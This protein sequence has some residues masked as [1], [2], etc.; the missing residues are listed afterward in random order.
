MSKRAGL[1]YIWLPALIALLS[2]GTSH[3][4]GLHFSQYY[5]TPM[6]LNPANTAL[7]SDADYRLGINY[8][9]QWAS[10][11]VPFN[12]FSAFADFQLLR[13]RNIT[14]WMGMG[15]A[16]FS[17]K[18]GDGQLAM[19]K[20]EGFLAYHVQTGN[21]S[22]FSVGGSAAYVQRSVDYGKL[23]FDRQWDGFK[24]D[25]SRNSMETGYKE[26]TDF[27]D[28]SAGVNYAYYPSDRT[29]IK[30]GI[31]V[32][33]VN[34]PK[35][36]FYGQN[37]TLKIRPTAN[38]D[39]IFIIGETFTVNPSLY[40]TR[41]AA[42]QQLVY[43]SQIKAFLS[44]DNM[45]NPTNIIAGIYHRYGDAIIG[46]LGFQWAGVKFITSYD[47]TM[48]KLAPTIRSSGALEFALIYEGS[49]HGERDKMNCPRF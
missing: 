4:Q 3:A 25:P 8:R 2:V 14:N 11:P 46:V 44:E 6:L 13:N 35:E 48:S 27:V 23:T 26:T 41:Q 28:V 32:A 36:T 47:F 42:A 19:N 15:F 7:T 45:G 40:Y 22:M 17:D 39:A 38:L 16:M 5:N 21:F 1:K 43:G 18:A 37:T 24:F 33:H 29:Y 12:T 20:Y 9:S 34:M 31:G 49:Y 10:L 30:L